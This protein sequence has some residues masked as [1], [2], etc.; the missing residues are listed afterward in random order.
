MITEETLKPL[1]GIRY[2]RWGGH[3]KDN[4][5]W[6]AIVLRGGDGLRQGDAYDYQR[7][8]YLI[9]SCKLKGY[10]YIVLKVSRKGQCIITESNVSDLKVGSEFRVG[11]KM[12]GA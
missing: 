12:R 5:F 3:P 9:D 4:K 11:L 8:Q 7:K 2:C 1:I 10:D 6:E